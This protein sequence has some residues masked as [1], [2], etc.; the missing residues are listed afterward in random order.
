MKAALI[1]ACVL[2]GCGTAAGAKPV[3]QTAAPAAPSL[4]YGHE[5]M[6]GFDIEDYLRHN[7]PHLLPHA[8]AISHWAGYSTIS[9]RVLLALIEQQSALLSTPSKDAAV[10]ATP[11]GKLSSR[12]GFEA[13]LR[14]VADRL[15]TRLYADAASE[16]RKE[17]GDDREFDFLFAP[18][19]EKTATAVVADDTQIAFT[20]TYHALFG[21]HYLAPGRGWKAAPDGADL[22]DGKSGAMAKQAPN[23][24]LQFPFPL[25]QTWHIGGA[26]TNSGSGSYPLSSLDLSQGGG[27]GSNQ[28][29]VWVAASAAGQF[30]RH[31]SCFAEIV[32]A[33]GW[34]TTYYHLMNIQYAT[35]ASV[36]RNTRFANPAN[37]PSQALCNGGGSTGPHLHWSLKRNGAWYHL[38]GSYLSGWRITAIGNSYDTNCYRFYLSRNGWWGCA[39]YYTH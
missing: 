32:H 6:F 19:A 22:E 36:A 10:L 38:D 28:Y 23:G 29:G 24:M 1:V 25:G 7:A 15:A 21:E 20:A 34:S 16:G 8:E 14:D 35:G 31:S 4:L 3:A 26:H 11:F 5:E 13:Q 30:K 9:P 12:H 37:T 39:G 27:W 17:F 33:D 18:V 2:L